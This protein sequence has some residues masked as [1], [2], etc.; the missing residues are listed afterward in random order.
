MRIRIA[1]P[2]DAGAAARLNESARPWLGSAQ[3]WDG[4]FERVWRS[5]M[6]DP[7]TI[8]LVADRDGCAEGLA[9]L[10][11]VS[12]DE[13]ALAALIVDAG[14][15][16]RPA[17]DRLLL[18]A[19]GWCRRFGRRWIRWAIRDDFALYQHVLAR[20]LGGWARIAGAWMAWE[21]AGPQAPGAGPSAAGAEAP[22]GAILDRWWPQKRQALWAPA[23][24]WRRLR[25]DDLRAAAQEGRLA[26]DPEAYAILSERP[27]GTIAAWAEGDGGRLARLFGA[28]RAQAEARGRPLRALLPDTPDLAAALGA[29]GFRPYVRYRV[30]EAPTATAPAAPCARV[31]A[32]AA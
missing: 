21:P 25:Q 1:A 13:A 8:V 2:R 31:R 30:W 29:A 4:A 14:R 32:G 18:F 9:A 23:W 11:A 3:V 19:L 10:V 16:A 5:W 17:R 22:V 15:R 24:M 7:S 28:L 20:E 12:P 27:Y 26:G 6:A